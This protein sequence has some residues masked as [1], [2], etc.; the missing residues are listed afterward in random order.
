[1][2]S[3]RSALPPRGLLGLVAGMTVVPLALL[4]WLGWRT[5]DQ[6]RLLEGLQA[7]QRLELAADLLAAALQRAVVA[8][9]QRLAADHREWP[10]GAVVIEFRAGLTRA[11]PRERV[12]YFPAVP[13]LPEAGAG[14][15]SEENALSSAVETTPR[16]FV[17]SANRRQR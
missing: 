5:L 2:A 6:D 4:A 15:F 10:E 9:A 3:I 7:R 8:D 16:P 17:S 14:A 12:A 13:A 1:M 11:H